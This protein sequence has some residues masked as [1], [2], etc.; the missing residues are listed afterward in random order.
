M[1]GQ[2]CE[3]SQFSPTPLILG[4]KLR[5]LGLHDNCLYLLNHLLIP[6]WEL[7]A[8]RPHPLFIERTGYGTQCHPWAR[9]LL[10]NYSCCPQS[11]FRADLLSLHSQCVHTVNH[12][13]PLS[14]CQAGAAFW[15]N[16]GQWGA[17]PVLMEH[18]LKNVFNNEKLSSGGLY[19][20]S[21]LESWHWGDWGRG[22]L[23]SKVSHT[24]RPFLAI[25]KRDCY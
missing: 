25:T 13:S 19:G 12:F 10:L 2:L 20:D 11:S 1:R 15:E 17:T 4:I 7:L 6:G 8:L 9:A 3:V 18:A 5:P 16:S 23:K 24:I 22:S 21:Y 14:E